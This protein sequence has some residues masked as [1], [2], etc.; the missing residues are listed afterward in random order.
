MNRGE[1]RPGGDGAERPVLDAAPPKGRRRVDPLAP[2]HRTVLGDELP[3]HL[4]RSGLIEPGDVVVVA[5][6]GGADSVALLHLLRFLLV[7]W[8]L[9]LVA[10]HYDHAMRTESTADADWVAGLCEAWG[11]PLER[12]RSR[13]ELRSEAEARTA[14]YRFLHDV[15]DRHAADR[16]ALAHHADDQ[17]ETVLFHA[18]RGTGLRGLAGIPERRG[19]IVRP[20]LPFRRADVM[21]YLLAARLSY[22]LDPT[23]LSGR[24]VRNRLRNEVIPRLESIVPGASRALARLAARAR[25]E[26]AAWESVLAGL[27]KELVVE[28]SEGCIELARPLLLEYHAEVRARVLRRILRRLGSVPDRAGTRSA[29]EFTTYGKSGAGI[30][31]AGGVRVEREFDRIRIRRTTPVESPLRDR[32]LVIETPDD[33]EGRV[34][35]GGREYSV[36]WGRALEESN[37]DAAISLRPEAVRFPLEVRPWRPGDRI[38]LPYGTKK[39]KKVFGERRVRRTERARVPVLAEV[40]GRILWIVGVA[41]SAVAE[42][43]PGHFR[44]EI[45]LTDAELA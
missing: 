5:V 19:R 14:R 20:L 2:L 44:I 34:T 9:R 16:L 17:A 4:R 15:A 21:E 42:S 33:G 26:E 12:E 43:E 23:N 10:A 6:S 24:Y 18:V 11:V 35:I 3:E 41:R 7:R 37:V 28:R 36:R 45:K 31:L 27:E 25:A 8:E 29:V 22:R 40:D 13:H 30:D 39:L 32:T 1:G 38:R